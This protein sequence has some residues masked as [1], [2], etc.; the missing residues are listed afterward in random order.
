M[1]FSIEKVSSRGAKK[2]SHC[3]VL[4]FT[5]EEGVVYLP[6]S[7]IHN[8]GLDVVNHSYV[9]LVNVSLPKGNSLPENSEPHKKQQQQQQKRIKKKKSFPLK[10]TMLGVLFIV[11]F[12]EN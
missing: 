10:E 9:K 5:A 1:M 12:E 8:L 11:F 2:K 7:M 4:E 6:L 3:S